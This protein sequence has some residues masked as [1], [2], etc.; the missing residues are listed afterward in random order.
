MLN[1]R[2]VLLAFAV[3]LAL[4]VPV[5]A[6]EQLVT[7][8]NFTF[9]PADITIHAGTSVIFKNSDDIPH[10]VVMADGSFH[11]KALDTDEKASVTFAK[12]GAF[13]YFCGLHPHMQGKI[14]VIP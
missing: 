4:G 6:A 14:T 10:S 13:A 11:S 7:I 2:S 9:K 8:E 1:L 3:S 5:S 12:V